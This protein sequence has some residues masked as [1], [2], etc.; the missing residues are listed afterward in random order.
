M[1]AGNGTP[2]AGVG[3]EVG[4]AEADGAVAGGAFWA[5]SG[6]AR[7]AIVATQ[8]LQIRSVKFIDSPLPTGFAITGPLPAP[9]DEA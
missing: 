7:P 6:R 3:W 2:G 8:T 1:P 9:S 4:A 5:M